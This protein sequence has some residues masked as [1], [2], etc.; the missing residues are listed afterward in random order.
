MRTFTVV[1][2]FEGE[3][4]FFELPDI[5]FQGDHLSF[6]ILFN[7][8]ELTEH[9]PDIL[10]SMIVTDP[11]GNTFI[12]PH[13]RWNAEKHI[14]TW[15][16]SSTETTYEGYLKCQLKCMSAEDPETIVCMS[17]ICQTRVYQ[18][19]E[20]AEDPPEAF[21]SWIDTLVQLGAQVSADA[22]AA[23]ASVEATQTN[24]HA[25]QAA[26][27]DASASAAAAQQAR[28]AAE[29]VAT[30]VINA[31]DAAVRAQQKA[32]QAAAEAEEAKGT[33]LEAAETITSALEEMDEDV[34]KVE[35]ASDQAIAAAEEA[36]NRQTAANEAKLAAERARDAAIFA[37]DGAEAAQEHAETAEEGALEA[38]RLAE[39]AQSKSEEA[40]SK[41]EEAQGKSEE[42]QAKSEEAQGKAETAQG[43]AEDAQ[44]AAE[45]ARDRAV[46]ARDGVEYYADYARRWAEG[47]TYE[48]RDVD[49]NDETYNNHSEYWA[50]QSAANANRM[51]DYLQDVESRTVIVRAMPF[52]IR[53]NAWSFSGS[54][55][56][57]WHVEIVDED[58]RSDY[59]PVIVF[60]ESSIQIAS[61]ASM[62]AA[63]YAT[64]GYV[65]VK[66]KERPE[67][68]LVGVL[69]LVGAEQSIPLI[70]RTTDWHAQEFGK[71]SYYAD[72][73]N[74]NIS[75]HRAPMVVL[76]EE[77]LQLASDAGVGTTIRSYAGRVRLWSTDLPE[78][79]LTGMLHLVGGG[80]NVDDDS[81]TPQPPD[82]SDIDVA[83]DDDV[84]EMIVDVFD[85]DEP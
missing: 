11:K 40:Q 63:I 66:A 59:I 25:A 1:P 19:L 38:K 48:G 45:N 57:P 21:Q 83:T 43:L 16:I 84:E 2:S 17:R 85:D 51:F 81:G 64:D 54:G 20:A 60:E 15:M 24:A 70:V 62:C 77:S 23:F 36:I 69:Y 7:L 65:Q 78:G 67:S 8:T 18:S 58:I 76:D 12:A 4:A 73:V 53:T 14:F 28:N 13:T 27:D 47:K 35:R 31:Q 37:K 68:T 79:D 26:A 75:E 22:E 41:S 5:G 74:T 56:Y 61:N 71:Y 52:T 30:N 3:S 72:I 42:A 46:T 49:Q 9:W 55:R 50:G 32:E 34:T 39:T 6:A 82:P 33:V 44:Q 80:I 10:P 29:S